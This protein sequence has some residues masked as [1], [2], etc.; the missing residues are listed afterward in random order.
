M[1][2]SSK[3][4]RK[5]QHASPP[6]R[7]APVRDLDWDPAREV[8]DA[9][10]LD[11]PDAPM[12]DDD[13]SAHLRKIVLEQSMF[14]GHSGFHAFITGAGTVPGAPA[15]LLAAGINQNLGGSRPA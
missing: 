2:S 5:S 4:P 15:D 12:S 13:L 11:V 1:S 9:L 8:G 10:A 14:P 7:P 3:P 6:R